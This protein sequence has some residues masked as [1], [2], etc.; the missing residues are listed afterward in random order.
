MAAGEAGARRVVRPRSRW[1]LVRDPAGKLLVVRDGQGRSRSRSGARAGGSGAARSDRQ[2]RGG[3]ARSCE[4]TT[5]RCSAS[6]G[7]AATTRSRSGSLATPRRSKSFDWLRRPCWTRPGSSRKSSCSKLSKR[8]SCSHRALKRPARRSHGHGQGPR[9]RAPETARTGPVAPRPVV[10]EALRRSRRSTSQTRSCSSRIR[11]RSGVDERKLL[12]GKS[13]SL[14]EHDAA[15]H[16]ATSPGA[17]TTTA[18]RSS[19]P[20]RSGSRT[21]TRTSSGSKPG[22]P[23]R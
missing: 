15:G 18:S 11:R 6:T 3:A 7:A 13:L 23:C 5:K 19:G 16:R 2:A 14:P 1:R 9:R 22:R 8:T 17:T 10:E 20:A 12:E 21:T 4:G